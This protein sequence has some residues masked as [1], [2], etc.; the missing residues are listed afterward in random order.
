MSMIKKIAAGAA[1][2][3]LCALLFNAALA[4][5]APLVYRVTD[6][7]G[8]RLYLLGT[9]HVGRS[10]MFPLGGAVEEAYA[11]SDIL[12]VEMDVIRAGNLFNAL[13]M[14]SAV[15]Y[16]DGDD[17]TNHLSPKT[18]ELGFAVLGL[19]EQT[20]RMMKPA[21]WLSLAENLGAEYGRLDTVHG[22]DYYLLVRARSDRKPVVELE[23][24]D[25]QMD[26]LNALSDEA[27]D[28]EIYAVLSD[29]EDY[30]MQMRALLDAWLIGDELALDYM[31]NSDAGDEFYE[32][33]IAGRNEA[34]LEQAVEYLSGEETVLIAIGAGH[35]IG[36]TGLARQLAALGYDVEEIGR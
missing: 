25:V 7:E 18:C 11:E 30:G 15:A 31:V 1:A 4:A 33:I 17:V 21:A 23:G 12:A 24:L 14:S 9:I 32:E 6:G 16:A 20:L 35:I 22:V 26:F 19:P 27:L 29:P 13:R 8:H 10:D 34:F 28:E 3:L 2:F 5:S 36:E